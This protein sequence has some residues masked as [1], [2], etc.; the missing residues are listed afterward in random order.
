MMA[1]FGTPPKGRPREMVRMQ[2]KYALKDGKIIETTGDDASVL[3]FYSLNDSERRYLVDELKVDEHTLGSALDPAELGRI[4]FEPEHT[5]IICKRP[6]RYTAED[7]FLFKVTTSGLF[8]FA[9]KIVIISE[10]DGLSFEGRLFTRVYSVTDV[11]LRM[12]YQTIIHFTEHLKVMNAICDDLESKVNTA[13]ENKHLLHMFTIE[14]G[15]VYYLHAISSNGRVLEKIKVNAARMR[16][17]TESQE[18]LEDL[19]IENAQCFE[20]ANTHAQ[21]LA[22]LMDARASL[23]SNNLNVM[24]KNLN[25]IVISVAVPSFFAAVGGMSEF[26][27]MTRHVNWIMTYSLFLL[28]M[29]GL[30]LATYFVVKKLEKFWH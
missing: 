24:M 21:V 30:G 26:S 1:E 25:A 28:S 14:K 29:F 3:V 7:N 5:A 10:K 8:L 4:E 2:V 27:M 22:S 18:Y 20:Q 19:L 16:F 15:L 6:K 12:L 23:V 17:S 11:F 9:D 13:M